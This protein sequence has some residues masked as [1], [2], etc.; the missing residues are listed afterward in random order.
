IVPV[1]LHRWRLLARRYNQSAMLAH[2]LARD[3]GVPVVADALRRTKRTRSQGGLSRAARH[4]N[5]RGVFAVRS[6]RADAL[7]GRRVVLVDDVLT[8]GATANACAR[9]LLGGGAAS[10]D[11]LTL[12]R[13]V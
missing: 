10:V 11:L 2:A 8:T 7:R 13:V 1:P 9:A 6:A 5:V 4:R 3:C 12:A